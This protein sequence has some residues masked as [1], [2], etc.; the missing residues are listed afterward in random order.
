MSVRSRLAKLEKQLGPDTSAALVIEVS[1][2]MDETR[3]AALARALQERGLSKD[4][5]TAAVFTGWEIGFQ[6]EVYK[7]GGEAALTEYAR[8]SK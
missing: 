7:P 3:E 4:L 2:D 6:T 8:G 1:V 5:L